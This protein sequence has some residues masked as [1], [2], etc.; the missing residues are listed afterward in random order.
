MKLHKAIDQVINSY[1]KDVLLKDNFVNIL[2]DLHAFE[3]STAP[4]YILRSAIKEGYLAK[5]TTYSQWNVACFGFIK[6]LVNKF[7]YDKQCVDEVLRYVAYS[8]G[9]LKDPLCK[10]K[11]SSTNINYEE[12]KEIIEKAAKGDVDSLNYCAKYHIDPFNCDC[13]FFTD[14]S[15][16]KIGD[17]MYEDGSFTHGKSD[18]KRIVGVVFSLSPTKA[19]QNDGWHTGRVVAFKDSE[20]CKWSEEFEDLSFPH[21][22]YTQA[23]VND[24]QNMKCFKDYGTEYINRTSDLPPFKSAKSV[25]IKLP[26]GKTSGWYMPDVNSLIEISKNLKTSILNQLSLISQYMYWSGSQFDANAALSVCFYSDGSISVQNVHV[27][28]NYCRVRSILAF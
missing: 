18:L 13:N 28:T 10:Q 23:D 21:T 6:S 19:E 24:F 14:Y 3:S 7:G 27:K 12:V 17:W 1:G 25:K 2:D 16:V 11:V 15:H 22:H 4:K 26:K 8:I 20:I 9:I 5:M